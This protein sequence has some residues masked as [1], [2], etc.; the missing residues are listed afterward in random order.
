MGSSP[1]IATL[2]A[3]GDIGISGGNDTYAP[4]FVGAAAACN[5]QAYTPPATSSGASVASLSSLSMS[6][7]NYATQLCT[8]GGA[9]TA[10][11]MANNALVAGGYSNG[12]YAGGSVNVSASTVLGSI[13]AGDM[14]TT[15]GST[16]VAG[17]LYN[18]A[19]GGASNAKNTLSGGS[20]IAPTG[21]SSSFNA[22]VPTCLTNCTQAST[23]RPANNIVW[24]SPI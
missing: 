13:L 11:T 22:S 5:G 16:Y 8:S 19:L 20:T 17:S 15:S 24:V 14:L 2:I 4:N 18:G 12:V 10:A 7:T 23:T 21:A 3:T 1:S 6:A 9:L